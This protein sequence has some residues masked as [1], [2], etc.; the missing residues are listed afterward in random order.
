MALHSKE[1]GLCPKEI[2]SEI[3]M[4]GEIKIMQTFDFVI[5][6]VTQELNPVNSCSLFMVH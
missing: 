4:L 5:Y 6:A 2:T 3:L 1:T